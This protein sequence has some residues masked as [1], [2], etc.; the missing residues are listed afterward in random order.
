MNKL[1]KQLFDGAQ[2]MEALDVHNAMHVVEQDSLTFPNATDVSPAT[3][4]RLCN[5]IAC[6][7]LMDVLHVLH[8][9]H[10]GS[11]RP[12]YRRLSIAGLLPEN[13]VIRFTFLLYSVF[14]LESIGRW[15]TG[16]S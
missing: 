9:A 11:E 6:Y 15:T 4:R 12:M 13:K 5:V 10:P 2:S 14:T 8:N 3:A 7:R 1:E 16:L